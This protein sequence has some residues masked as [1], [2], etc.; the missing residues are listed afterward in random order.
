[1]IISFKRI[2][3]SIVLAGVAILPALHAESVQGRFHL[4]VAAYLG[5]TLL[6]PGDYRISLAQTNSGLKNVAIVGTGGYAYALPLVVEKQFSNGV[7]SLRLVEV[8]GNYFVEEFR[9]RE[10]GKVYS[11]ELSKKITAQA[12]KSVEITN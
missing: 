1:M 10:T 7:S 3:S 6:R 12:G 11:F 5:Q 9:S 8:G 2:C 4:R